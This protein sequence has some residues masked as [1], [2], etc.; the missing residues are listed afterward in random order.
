MGLRID[1]DSHP[2]IP[3]RESHLKGTLRRLELTFWTIIAPEILPAWALNRL[4][5]AMMV[6]DVYNKEK[7]VLPNEE[8]ATHAR[9]RFTTEARFNV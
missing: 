3:P 4:L 6:R 5:A 9:S 8:N 2:N 1:D 7:G